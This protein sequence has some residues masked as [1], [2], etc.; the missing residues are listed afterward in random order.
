MFG[1][2]DSRV[3]RFI[4]T[5]MNQI[6]ESADINRIYS[7]GCQSAALALHIILSTIFEEVEM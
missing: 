3:S 4:R 2:F 5:W 6:D 1:G 7:L